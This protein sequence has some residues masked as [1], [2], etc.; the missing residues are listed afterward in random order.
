MVVQADKASMATGSAVLINFRN[1]HG[2]RGMQ[3]TR[4]LPAQVAA[5]SQLVCHPKPRRFLVAARSWPDNCLSAGMAQSAATNCLNRLIGMLLFSCTAEFP[6][7]KTTAH[8]NDDYQAVPY[9]PPA[10]LV[11]VAG[12]P[13]NDACVWYDGHWAWRNNKYVWKRGGWVTSHEDLYYARGHT[14]VAPDGQLMFTEGTWYNGAGHRVPEPPIVRPARTPPN[15]VTS[16]FES[17]R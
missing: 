2:I 8:A 9:M 11:E 13:P 10:A 1:V 4:L 17:P 12:A 15:H 3:P 5:L 16:E 7:P 14:V 6:E